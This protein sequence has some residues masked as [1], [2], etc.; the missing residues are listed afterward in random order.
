MSPPLPLLPPALGLM[1][2]TPQGGAAASGYRLPAAALQAIVDAPR[3]PALSLSPRRDLALLVQ[4]PPL[5]S[6]VEVAQPELKLAGMRINPR[7]YSASRFSFGCDLTLLELGSGKQSKIR[8]L[9]RALRLADLSW[10]PD[11]RHA[12]FT[13]VA[14]SGD[15]GAV[16]LWL[17]D[18][19][20]RAARRL[21]AQPLSAVLG[22][23][24]QWMPDSAGLLIQ[25]RPS[26][27]CKPPQGSGV[28]N[29][30]K[31]QD[32]CPDGGKRQLRSYQDLLHN[33]DDARLF[34]HYV[35]GQLALLDLHGRSRPVG[36]PEQYLQVA[37]APGGQYLLTQCLLRP[38]STLVPV[39]SFGRRIEVRTLD[40][41][42]V[43][44]VGEVATQEGLPAG[45]D[46]VPLGLR[47]VGW[48]S[49]A[50]AT[51]AWVEAQDGGDPAVAAEVRDI[52]YQ[53]AAPFQAAPQP[54]L[55]L[56]MRFS[57]IAWGRADLAL[58]SERW[59]KTRAVRQWRVAPERPGR[60][61][62]L[63]YSGS[64]EDRYNSP[65]NPVL[66]AGENGYPR[67]MIGADDSI[68]LAGAGATPAGE[69]PFV[70]RLS[71]VTR[72]KERLFQSA[73][74]YFE[75]VM[76]VLNDEGTRLLTTREAPG[77]RPNFY[78]RELGMPAEARLVALTH[79]PHPTPQ[80]REVQK[81]QIRYRRADGVD[82]TATLLLPPGYEA[83]RD[84]PLP[85]L[86]WAYPQ[87][88]K[89]A[90]AASQTTG[91]PHRFNAISYWGPAALLAMGYAV[92]DNPSFPIVGES[93]REPNDSYLPQLV[94]SA[95]AAVDEVVRRGVAER[96][97]IA[98][99]GHSYGAFMVANLLAHTRLFRAGI[100]RS[101]AYNRTL[102]PFG[103]QYEE[104]PFWQAPE[105]YQA[106]SPF[107]HADRIKDALL[108]IHGEQDNN[109]GTY[110]LQSERLFQ[111]I[112]GLGGTARLVMLPSESHA[113][114]A[115]E[116]ILHMLHETHAWLEQ[117]VRQAQP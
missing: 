49:D 21:L 77:E 83:A 110:P 58:V 9:P 37:V 40:C 47:H 62:E 39:S 75:N 29:G 27:Q 111:A 15:T 61:A 88:F 93:G 14:Y 74:P 19:A 81:E 68:V 16:E 115:R 36:R 84:G 79:F 53:Q 67:L 96:H 48:R 90:S 3:A 55:K 17:L 101:G 22:R 34:E 56:A 54:L 52:V 38:Y 18:V 95:E 46:A 85:L 60:A 23:G 24:F 35:T 71:L 102:T 94:A 32:S 63:I 82:L 12:V 116:S 42:L 8:G 114:R 76:A 1:S 69:R 70:D 41:R 109:A 50:P 7:T 20:A 13:H 113:Y 103:F 97:R 80:L 107:N 105:V 73:P 66:R 31:L 65:G 28:P 87:E 2:A 91:S 33:E 26:A 6:I 59:H 30:P 99:G 104:R 98:I 44:T 64:Y 10:S 43:H 106:M 117:H 108:L 11:Q 100:A 112:R 86:M 72:H 78:L 4:T 45:N 92:L 5:P 25:L 89:S 57:G 51:L